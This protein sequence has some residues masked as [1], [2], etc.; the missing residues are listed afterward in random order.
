MIRIITEI[1]ANI[2]YASLVIY[3]EPETHLHP[4][5]ITQLINA[6]YNLTNEFQSYCI[7]ATHS[8]LIVR[9]LLSSNV[10]IMEREENILSIRKPI[11][12]TF[13]ENLTVI[14]EDIFGN[15]S[16]PN[17]YKEILNHLV[18]S[19]KTFDE[20]VSLISTENI[21]LS[22]NTRIYLKSIIDEK[23]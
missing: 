21:P 7:L 22:L 15:N 10:Y 11:R 23:S 17:Q 12:E 4:N 14:T 18:L 6:I 16:I 1:V 5:A 20:I 3:D 2:R 19:G 9:E 13:G 8:P